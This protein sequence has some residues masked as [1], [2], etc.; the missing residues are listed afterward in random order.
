M[1]PDHLVFVL[2]D[3]KGGSAF[4]A[5]AHLPHVVGLVTDLDERLAMRALICLEAELR[6]REERLRGTGAADLGCLLVG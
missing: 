3:Y 1:D 5:C 4:D 6:Y 2:M